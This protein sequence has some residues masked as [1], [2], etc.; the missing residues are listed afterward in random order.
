L[1]LTLH[2]YLALEHLL[3]APGWSPGN[4][5]DTEL[6]RRGLTRRV[7]MQ[8]SSFLVAPQ[9]VAESDLVSTG[10]SLLLRGVSAHHP[11]VLRKAPLLR[12][13][14][15]LVWHTR[16]AHDPAH[17]WMREVVVRAAR[18]ALAPSTSPRRL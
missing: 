7:A 3:V 15:C 6:A 12:F 1:R 5:G 16:R 14:L 11:V 9:L 4:F 17:V 18:V 2:R 8:I 13:E 10:P